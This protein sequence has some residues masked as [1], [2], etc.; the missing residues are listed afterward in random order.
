MK[1]LFVAPRFHTNQ[2]AWTKALVENGHEVQFWTWWEDTGPENYSAL[3]PEKIQT[4]SLSRFLLGLVKKQE[5]RNAWSAL[6][7][8]PKIFLF[9]KKFKKYN[10]DVLIARHPNKFLISFISL[11]FAKLNKTQIIIYTQT[12]LHKKMKP[13]NR[14][15]MKVFVFIFGAKWITTAP[16]D[17]EKYPKFHQN[18]F[19]A[20]FA[21]DA[22][23]IPK[24]QEY[25]TSRVDIISIGKLHQ[26]RKNNLLLLQALK[27]IEGELDFHLTLIGSLLSAEEPIYKKILKYIED[28]NL[29]NKVTVKANLPHKEVLEEYAKNDLF[30]LPSSNEQSAYSHL[31]AMAAGLPV[32]CSDTNR[33]RYYVEEGGNGYIFKSDDVDDLVR[34]IKLIVKD[35]DNI[36]KMGRRSVE[37]VRQH[38]TMDAFYKNLLKIIS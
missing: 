23:I 18:A 11:I 15:L 36:R 5:K 3:K 2:Y 27:K 7:A 13:L 25:D 30:V 37:I 34:K 38:Y 22:S 17:K 14:L 4:S 28:N 19:Y 20:P 24:K 8:F 32:I 33:T 10:P 29:E 9:Y 21:V 1:F 12:P 16:G 26:S 31:E 35:K 6:F